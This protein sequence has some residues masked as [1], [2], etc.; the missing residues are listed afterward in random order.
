MK[1]DGCGPVDTVVSAY[2]REQYNNTVE[3][4]ARQP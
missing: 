3:S 4:Q 1:S 2:K